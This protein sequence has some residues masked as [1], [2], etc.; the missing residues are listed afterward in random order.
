LRFSARIDR[1]ANIIITVIGD[2]HQ[3]SI[4]FP[5]VDPALEPA[6]LRDLHARTARAHA[7]NG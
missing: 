5:G 3:P 1:F 4:E 6:A 7:G 2:Y